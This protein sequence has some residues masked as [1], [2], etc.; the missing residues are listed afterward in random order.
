MKKIFIVLFLL[1]LVGCGKVKTDE[2]NN[3]IE[4]KLAKD[5]L[6]NKYLSNNKI[7]KGGYYFIEEGYVYYYARTLK[8]NKER[9][10]ERGTWDIQNDALMLYASET[11]MAIKDE[12]GKYSFKP[13]RTILSHKFKIEKVDEKNI[14]FDTKRFIDNTNNLS[15]EKK[16][17]YISYIK[18]GFEKF[19]YEKI[20]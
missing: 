16:E 6:Y 4:A 10:I 3:L 19:D 20:K 15:E 2:Q 7:D 11:V 1:L 18:N 14:T 5:Y 12:K 17:E 8:S 9:V 13:T